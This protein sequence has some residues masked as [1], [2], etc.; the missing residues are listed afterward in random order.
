MYASGEGPT[1]SAVKTAKEGS[2]RRY[3]VDPSNLDVTNQELPRHPKVSC[4]P[5]YMY[6]NSFRIFIFFLF[7]TRGV[8]NIFFVAWADYN[9]IGTKL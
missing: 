7:K 4:Q 9:I 5:T 8:F 2:S 1:Q 3:E 6:A